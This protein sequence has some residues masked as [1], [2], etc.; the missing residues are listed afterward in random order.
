M[1][2][3]LNIFTKEIKLVME[4]LHNFLFVTDDDA[5]MSKFVDCCSNHSTIL[6]LAF[7]PKKNN[8]HGIC[9][10]TKAV[11]NEVLKSILQ[12]L[13]LFN[14]PN[15]KVFYVLDNQ[16]YACQLTDNVVDTAITVYNYARDVAYTIE[17]DLLDPTVRGHISRWLCNN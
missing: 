5:K 9:G 12:T 8:M 10:R 13:C 7:L 2:P 3:V 1:Y 11:P 17:G 4:Y 16:T 6:H 15:V 14:D